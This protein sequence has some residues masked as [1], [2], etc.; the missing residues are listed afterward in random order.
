MWAAKGGGDLMMS[1]NNLNF[2]IERES[3]MCL[4]YICSLCLI[5]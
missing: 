3:V 2:K 5:C 4:C 1:E